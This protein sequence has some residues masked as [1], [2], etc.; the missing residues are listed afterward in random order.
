MLP[1]ETDPA[2][3]PQRP[4]V[5]SFNLLCAPKREFCL[6]FLFHGCRAG[7]SPGPTGGHVSHFLPETGG[8]VAMLSPNRAPKGRTTLAQAKR[9]GSE[10]PFPSACKP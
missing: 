7:A 10:N 4:A 2:Y 6:R 5:P 1:G 9:P 3:P 8:M